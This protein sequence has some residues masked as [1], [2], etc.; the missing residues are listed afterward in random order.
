MK[1]ITVMTAGLALAGSAMA[2]GSQYGNIPKPIEISVGG[3]WF[4]GDLHTAGFTNT[5]WMADIDYMLNQFGVGSVGFV[6]ARGWFADQS[7]MKV[8]TYGVH[9]GVRFSMP[10]S[11]RTSSGSGDFYAKLALG[12]YTTQLSPGTNKWGLGGFLG[13]GYGFAQTGIGVEA[14]YQ[15]GPSNSGLD[16]R[17]WYA[18]LT[19]RM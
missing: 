13:V 2:S 19:F 16:N 9:Y 10:M 5:A 7:G 4:T 6:G 14:G 8:N 12:Y 1:T 3:T 18:A 15:L 11:T 17:S